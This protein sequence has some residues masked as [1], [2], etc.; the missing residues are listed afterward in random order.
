[1]RQDVR[2][3]WGHCN[4]VNWNQ[5]KFAKCFQLMDSLVRALNLSPAE[6]KRIT[7]ELQHWETKGK[8]NRLGIN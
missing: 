2:N 7:D 5:V 3:E 8:L 1:V 6:Q 4:F